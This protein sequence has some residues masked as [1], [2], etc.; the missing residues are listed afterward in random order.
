[1]NKVVLPRRGD[2]DGVALVLVVGSML[3]LAML[4]MTALAYTMSSEKFA[5][6]DQDYSASVS[7]AQTGVEDFISRL[8]R[9][10]T[11]GQV[12]DCTNQAWEGPM[13]PLSN[14]CGWST[15]TLPKWLP[16]TPGETDPTK[17]WFHYSVNASTRDTEGTIVLTST[18]RVNGEYRT[19]EV[20]VGK[21]GSTDYV[22]YTDFESADPTNTQVYGTGGTSR[23]ACGKNGYQNASYFYEG[24]R[25]CTEIQ[26]I[27]ADH[28]VG[29]VFTNDAIL[30][31]GA[32]FEKGVW[33][34]NP[35]CPKPGEPNPHWN[36]CLRS[37][38]TANFHSIAPVRADPL[39]LD[40]TSAAF[41]SHPGCHYFGSTRVVFSADGTMRVWNKKSVNGLAA[42]LAVPAPGGTT[43]G[44]G[45]LNDLDSEA[46]ALV[47]VP[48]EMVIYVAASTAS[49]RQCFKDE[50]GGPAGKTLPLGTYD[51]GY[52][53]A[54]TRSASYTFD[55]NMLETT[56]FCA[57]GNL[58][59][60]GV[61]KGRTT[62]AAAQSIIVT[63]D[64]V[65]AGGPLGPDILG[66]VATNSV[67]VF[68]PRLATV[69]SHKYSS[70]W[71]WDG[72]TGESDVTGWPYR[73]TDPATGT[74]NPA[75]GVQI[76]GS[77]QTLQHSFLVQMYDKGSDAGT[78]YVYGSI[79]QRWRGIVGTGSGTTGYSKQ[80]NYDTRLQYSAPPYFPRWAKSQWSLRYSG[81]VNTSSI[82]KSS[83]P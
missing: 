36:D 64:V 21:G 19:I 51:S 33:T 9:A 70:V 65:L 1:M 30:S 14:T 41:A 4:A 68:H 27:S 73:Y 18:G 58:Y 12:V 26:F 52:V 44:C 40:D 50:L 66:L 24:R 82:V 72:P 54:P 34:A 15:S 57:A 49:P 60:Q 48:N 63:G 79:A 47:N 69:E 13:D 59:V 62:L 42:P 83:T 31:S 43:P 3:V 25:G 5:R 61:L 77:I 76:A 10:D 71:K 45:S 39:Y 38:S 11:Y 78:L 37:G 23:I 32:H 56:K 17:A 7:A 6:Y 75:S 81:E 80:Y 8:N 74:K 46:G 2:D 35:S 55:T 20:A 53:A 28:L 22:Y 16:V 29:K 67:E